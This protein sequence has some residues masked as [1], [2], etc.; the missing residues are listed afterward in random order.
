MGASANTIKP[1]F[2]TAVFLSNRLQAQRFDGTLT[3]ATHVKHVEA[4]V[5]LDG[6]FFPTMEVIEWKFPESHDGTFGKPW[7][8]AYNPQV[9]WQTQ[10][11]C[12]REYSSQTSV[13]IRSTEH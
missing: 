8:E 6:Y 10:E 12:L 7:F 3:P 9:N 1:G 4:S 11:I 5:C 13:G 2:A